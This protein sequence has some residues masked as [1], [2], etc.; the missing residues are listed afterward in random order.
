[1]Y[2]GGPNGPA[3]MATD[4]M[5]LGGVHM[6]GGEMMAPTPADPTLPM[7]GPVG[8]MVEPIEPGAD[9]SAHQQSPQW[10]RTASSPGGRSILHNRAG[11]AAPAGGATSTPGLIGPLGYD[12][13][14]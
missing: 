9:P 5:P 4:G 11:G 2:G 14:K 7:D 13:Q 10:Q 1:M 8:P 6:D 12:V 3:A